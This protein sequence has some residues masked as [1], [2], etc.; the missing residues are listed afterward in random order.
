M[1]GKPEQSGILIGTGFRPRFASGY[2]MFVRDGHIL[3]QPFNPQTF[4]LSGDPQTVGESGGFSVSP[5]GVLAY[6]ET[7]A[8]SEMKILDR[9]GNVIATPG[10]R[11]EYYEPKFSPDGMSIAVAVRDPRSGERDVWVYPAAGGQP[12]RITFGADD[13]WPHWSAD[14]KEIEYSVRDN[15]KASFRRRTL[16]GSQPEEIL[17]TLTDEAYVRAQAIDWSPDGKYLAFDQM[18]K[19]GVWSVW[20]L[21]LAGDRRPFRPPAISSMSVSGYDGLFSPDS[22]WLA[23]FSY[24]TG[25]PEVYVIPFLSDGAKYQVSTTGAYIPHFSRSS[26][27]FFF[28]TMGNRLMVGQ[29]AK[30]ASFRIDATRPLFQMDLP[31]FASPSYDVSADGQRFVVLTT[32]HTKSTSI[33]LL[34]NWL[35]ALKN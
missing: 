21:P 18:T 9:S 24:E 13:F 20:V 5:N 22:R 15:G 12:T 25:R 33:T 31:N 4:K 11:A 16:D 1:L 3:A 28:A 2:L 8:Q 26:G 19:E 35:A 29:V 23:Y 6:H 14:G 27:E 7:S 34:T 17:Y 30:Q 32:D 10:P